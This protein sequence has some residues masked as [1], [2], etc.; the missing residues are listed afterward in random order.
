MKTEKVTDKNKIHSGWWWIPGR[1]KQKAQGSLYLPT[2]GIIKL[3]LHDNLGVN[4]SINPQII[5][6][7]AI[8]GKEFTL[9]NNAGA[10]FISGLSG[11][12]CSFNPA[13]V[14]EGAHISDLSKQL[15][16]DL[17]VDFTHLE[18]W[19]A[20]QTIFGEGFLND[21]FSRIIANGY[22][23]AEFF[24]QKSPKLRLV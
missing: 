6:G 23:Y 20:E 3:E 24:G 11:Y 15:F 9:L 22:G 2:D 7:I 17:V 1:K 13:I 21:D 19:C 4:G 18:E 16:T 14:L 10:E 5:H 12:Y 8:S